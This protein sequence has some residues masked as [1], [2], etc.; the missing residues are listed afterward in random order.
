MRSSLP[1][2]VTHMP[3]AR[4][5]KP[6]LPLPVHPCRRDLK[7]LR[8]PPSSHP[9][10]RPPPQTLRPPLPAHTPAAVASNPCG[11]QPLLRLLQLTTPAIGP[12][13]L[14]PRCIRRSHPGASVPHTPAPSAS[15]PAHTP[16]AARHL[17][18]LH[19]PSQATPPAA[20][21]HAQATSNT[22]KPATHSS[23]PSPAARHPQTQLPL[24]VTPLPAG[25]IKPMRPPDSLS[26]IC[27]QPHPGHRAARPHTHWLPPAPHTPV[28]SRPSH[29]CALQPP[30]S[31]HPCQAR[32]HPQPHPPSHRDEA[33]VLANQLRLRTPRPSS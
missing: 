33:K 12:P 25:H 8:L 3:A 32:P 5:L 31:S 17:K 27:S 24:P 28:G 7:P 18:P 30:L 14:T 6:A 29:P 21:P 4:H 13:R 10:R 15:L 19:Y 22:L 2:Q 9:C 20:R 1:S 11:S 16:A 26:G 23:H